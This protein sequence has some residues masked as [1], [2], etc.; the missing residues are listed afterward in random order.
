KL[1]GLA[2]VE[3]ALVQRAPADDAVDAGVRDVA[4]PSDI[5]YVAD[6]AGGDHRDVDGLGQA[7][8]RLHVDPAHHAVALDVGVD[9][10]LDAVVLEVPRHVDDVVARQL[11]PALGGHAPVAGVEPDDHPARKF[12]AQVGDEMRLVDGLG[13]DDDEAGPGLEVGFHHLLVADAAADLYRQIRVGV[14]DA[15]DDLGVD[16]LAGHSAVE[17]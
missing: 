13:A 12:G 7:R 15:P 8:G 6:A 14:H 16:R 10:G 1:L 5:L 17:V 11:G 3:G 2:E 9:D 4:K